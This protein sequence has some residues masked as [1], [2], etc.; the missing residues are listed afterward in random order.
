MISLLTN[1]PL[2]FEQIV[3][4]VELFNLVLTTHGTPCL[5]QGMIHPI[6]FKYCEN[7]INSLMLN[8]QTGENLIQ[9]VRDCLVVH[10]AI[11]HCDGDGMY[12][13][14]PALSNTNDLQA[15]AAAHLVLQQYSNQLLGPLINIAVFS[16]INSNEITDSS[17]S[18][19]FQK[20]TF[21]LNL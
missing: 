12:N 13:C 20:R 6:L 10:K 11:I 7:L 1:K 16:I 9:Y 5:K 14:A 8:T 21:F 18:Y 19:K 3:S 4:H 15:R 2:Q 17:I